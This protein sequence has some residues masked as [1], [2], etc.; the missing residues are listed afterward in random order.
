MCVTVSQLPTCLPL[1]SVYISNVNLRCKS[2]STQHC[3]HC[4][5][6]TWLV[7]TAPSRPYAALAASVHRDWACWLGFVLHHFVAG[8]ARGASRR[9]TTHGSEDLRTFTLS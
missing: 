8:L 7:S 2:L 1:Y 9:P 5:Y 6:L 3:A 4:D